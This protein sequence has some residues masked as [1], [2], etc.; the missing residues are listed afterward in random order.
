MGLLKKISFTL[1]QI[2]FTYK[3]KVIGLGEEKENSGEAFF[4]SVGHG[5]PTMGTT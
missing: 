1:R 5:P 3:I 4:Q 2:P